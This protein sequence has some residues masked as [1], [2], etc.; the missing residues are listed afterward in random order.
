MDSSFSDRASHRPASNGYNSHNLASSSMYFHPSPPTPSLNSRRSIPAMSAY[1]D[2]FITGPK[3]APS[4]R[5]PIDIQR[6]AAATALKSG[7]GASRPSTT[8]QPPS[9]SSSSRRPYT[10][11]SQRPPASFHAQSLSGTSAALN[12]SRRGPGSS[13]LPHGPST[14]PGY[15]EN[16]N[17]SLGGNSNHDNLGHAAAVDIDSS[18]CMVFET[19]ISGEVYE[20]L[21]T[22]GSD[23]I[24][25]YSECAIMNCPEAKLASEEEQNNHP[26]GISLPAAAASRLPMLAPEDPGSDDSSMDETDDIFD[27]PIPTYGRPSV[28]ATQVRAGGIAPGA[29]SKSQSPQSSEHRRPVTPPSVNAFGFPVSNVSHEPHSSHFLWEGQLMQKCSLC[30]ALVFRTRDRI[31]LH[32]TPPVWFPLPIVKYAFL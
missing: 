27:S 5:N 8:M 4:H 17:L 11:P 22:L 25:R 20:C 7:G 23:S 24:A 2:S 9:S 28:R 15:S 19:T 26:S 16:G 10:A 31:L 18:S 13:Q 30:F 6:S 29:T 1:N 14:A 12:L 21:R 3:R 32:P